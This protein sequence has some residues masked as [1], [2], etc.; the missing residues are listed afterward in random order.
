[1][2]KENWNFQQVW[3]TSVSLLKERS[4]DQENLCFQTEMFMMDNSMNS[5]WT[6]KEN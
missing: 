1:M 6:A 2:D 4:F 5:K 3:L